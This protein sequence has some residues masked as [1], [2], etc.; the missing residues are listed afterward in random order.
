MKKFL[1]PLVFLVLVGLTFSTAPAQIFRQKRDVQRREVQK[2]ENQR[3]VASKR[4]KN[5]S[6][7]YRTVE[8]FSDGGGVVLKWTTEFEVDNIGFD[9]YRIDGGKR[10]KVNQ[11]I[12]E[13]SG[14]IGGSG[15]QSAGEYVFFD[16]DGGLSSIYQIENISVNRTNHRSPGVFPKFESNLQNVTSAAYTYRPR[17]VLSK[18]VQ[19]LSYD[20]PN[21]PSELKSIADESDSLVDPVKQRAVAAQ[22]GVKIGITSRG[23]YRVTN[24]ELQN[25]GFDLNQPREKWQ[26][27]LNGVE[28]AISVTANY[29]EFFGKGI[30]T[31]YTGKNIYFLTAGSENGKRIADTF[32][33]PIGGN[34]DGNY[35]DYTLENKSRTTYFPKLLNGDLQNYFGPL[36]SST[37]PLIYNFDVRG[38]DFSSASSTIAIALQGFTSAQHSVKIKLNGVEIQT[39]DGNN[40]EFYSKTMTFQ[41]QILKEGQNSLEMISLAGSGDFSLFSD[42]KLDYRR[43]YK[44]ELNQLEF[45]TRDLRD[46]DVGG[47]TSADI[48]VWDITFPDTP[49]LVTN[50][51]PK[52]LNTQNSEFGVNLLSSRQANMFAFTNAATK[53]VASIIQNFP[54][55]LSSV[56]NNAD[57]III[58]PRIWLTEANV[59]ADYR[60]NDGMV[61]EVIDV[62]DTFDEFSYGVNDP[63]AMKAMFNYAKNNWQTPPKY[64]LLIGDST[65]DPR[66][67]TNAPDI[68]FMP[69]RFVDTLYE[70]TISDDYLTDFNNDGLTEIAIG[71][72]P[73]KSAQDIT[74]IYNK[75]VNFESTLSTA[76]ARGSLCASDEPRGYDFQSLC[77]RTQKELPS[78]I[79]TTEVNRQEADSKNKLLAAMNKGQYIVNYS[80]HGTTGVWAS[81]SFFGLDDAPNLSNQDK[82]SIYVMLTCLNGYFI[83]TKFDSLSEVLLKNPNGGAVVTWS[84]SGETTPDIQ[85]IMARRFFG[86]LGSSS[87]FNRMGDFVSDAKSSLTGGRDVKLSWVL[88]GDPTLKVK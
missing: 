3:T 50:T 43:L 36:V 32:R 13:G 34:V 52:A 83:R 20:A 67:Y 78:S 74:S 86:K 1:N 30:D 14:L 10:I 51:S 59:W 60:R 61:V 53:Q 8:A 62:E 5:D 31:T 35:Y 85:E 63:G 41:T 2:T 37:S 45:Y 33:R 68:N 79:P 16:N 82:L 76:Q 70:E 9:I 46:T 48:R 18:K 88:L 49:Q 7:S 72:I 47:F 65:S 71:R 58:T 56:S 40:R 42:L 44:A 73:A 12:V 21:L 57:L 75:V 4:Q 22:P 29:I 55:T 23:V 80:G 84:S 24:A 87:E 28:Q 19:A 15:P 54:S 17:S 77:L 26:L 69:V 39:I 38:V 64:V 25:S 66:N 27:Y 11:T 81:T 6:L